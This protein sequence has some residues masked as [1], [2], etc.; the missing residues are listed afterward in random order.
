MS[1]ASVVMFIAIVFFTLWFT[2]QMQ[3]RDQEITYTQF[4]R[5]LKDGNVA[6]AIVGQSKAV[7]TGTVTVTLNNPRASRIV[8]V[9]DVNEVQ[10]L[11]AKYNVE[12]QMLKVQE[13]TLFTTVVLPILITMAGVLLIFMLMN[14]QGGGG[15]NAKAMN[16]GKSRARLN[17][18]ADKQVTF[19]EVAG[20][21]EEKEEL[22]EIVD[23]LKAQIG[24]AH[25]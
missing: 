7:P 16:F 21:K 12:Y 4:E 20:L 9:S 2:G 15:A 6:A 5:E 8:Y 3:Q 1:G 19:A 10:A 17:S 23:F 13:D 14:R 11:L 18:P 25:V 22:E 24:R